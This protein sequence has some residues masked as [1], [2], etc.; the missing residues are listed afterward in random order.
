MDA[1]LDR[2]RAAAE[3]DEEAFAALVK[4]YASRLRWLVRLRLDP[5]LRARVSADD[6]LQDAFVVA[7]RHIRDFVARD[8]AAFWSWL[9]RVVEHRLIDLHRRHLEAGRR[10]ARREVPAEPVVGTDEGGVD[11]IAFDPPALDQSSPSERLKSAEQRAIL[12]EALGELLPQHREVILL[13]VLEGQ[14]TAETAEILGRTPGAVSVLLHKA[15]K[16]L[17]A[18]LGRHSI[19]LGP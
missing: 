1:P 3:G 5:A 10:D 13:R 12:E 4:T 8:E 9:C 19:D 16:R 11:T 2:I 17:A 18:S 7:S 15:M 6:V 14:S